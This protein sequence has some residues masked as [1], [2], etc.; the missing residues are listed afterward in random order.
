ME[1]AMGNFISIEGLRP[2]Q[3]WSTH[4]GAIKGC[5]NYLG[6]PVST[7]WVY[8]ALGH[9]F[10][11]NIH[12]ETCPS[13]PTAWCSSPIFR[14][15]PNIGMSI[16]GVCSVRAFAND[17][18]EDQERAFKYIRAALERGLPCY[19]WELGIPEFYTIQGIDDAG[20]YY[21]GCFA[22]D[23]AGPK[24]WQELGLTDIGILEAYSIETCDAND[25]ITTVR[26]A[27]S[28]ALKFARDP[29]DLLLPNYNSGIE[30][31]RLWAEALRTG[32]AIEF[33]HSYNAEVWAECRVMAVEFLRE[34]RV[35]LAGIADEH[36]DESIG[37]YEQVRDRLLSVRSLHPFT[38][39]SHD[40]MTKKL[41][42]EESAQLLN[43]AGDWESKALD[44]LAKLA[45]SLGT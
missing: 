16:D 17:F 1:V 42:C 40:D 25:D 3:L 35:R 30:A 34:A 6:L 38:A 43:E 39:Q 4:I 18:A 2:E 5:A 15:A 26:D 20:Y 33:G 11:L 31:Y 44:S 7:P 14:L 29:G 8:G 45:E 27:I 19:G 9:A 22:E 37:F 32:I 41:N 36:F 24:P 21:T 10:V 12:A 23:G 28:F 13:G